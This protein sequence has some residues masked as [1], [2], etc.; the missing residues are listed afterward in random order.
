M[1]TL[2]LEKQRF[3]VLELEFETKINGLNLNDSDLDTVRE[4]LKNDNVGIRLEE[5]KTC[6]SNWPTLQHEETGWWENVRGIIPIIISIVAIIATVA[7]VFWG[8]RAAEMAKTRNIVERSRVSLG[9][10]MN[11]VMWEMGHKKRFTASDH[12]YSYV[13][14]TLPTV[15]FDSVISSGYFLHF[16]AETQAALRIVFLQIKGHNQKITELEDLR[17]KMDS[18]VSTFKSKKSFIRIV[19]SLHLIDQDIVYRIEKVWERDP[20]MNVNHT[21]R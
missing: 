5:S 3:A 8:I 15:A 10:E 18:K 12:E 1:D 4:Y 13:P 20:V 2:D 19:Q 7:G 6:I 11:D 14:Y 17:S 9:M 16:S 21:D